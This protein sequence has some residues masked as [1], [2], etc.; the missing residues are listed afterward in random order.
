MPPRIQVRRERFFLV[1]TGSVTLSLSGPPWRRRLHWC[2]RLRRPCRRLPS[3]S[4]PSASAPSAP[5]STACGPASASDSIGVGIYRRRHPCGVGTWGVGFLGV[6]N[7]GGHGEGDGHGHTAAGGRLGRDGAAVSGD[8]GRDDGKAET[9]ATVVPAPGRVDPVEALE[10]PGRILGRHAGP[11]VVDDH[12][13]H[14]AGLID[15]HRGRGALRGVGAHVGQEIVDH[16]AQPGGIAQHLDRVRRGERH[17]PERA[18]G[19]G[20][21]H[22]F[23]AQADQFGRR[24]SA[25]AALHR[26]GPASSRSVTNRSMRPVSERMPEMTRGRSSALVDAPRSKSSA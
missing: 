12:P 22:R 13:G 9:R 16:L 5:T 24:G 15:V 20:G 1:L 8:D 6:Q 26:A 19:G 17:R 10:H 23:G 18:H 21:V 14:R 7:V 11:V 4:A 25:G 2:P 3:A